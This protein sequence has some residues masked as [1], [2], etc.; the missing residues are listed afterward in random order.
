MGRTNLGKPRV[1]PEYFTGR[2]SLKELVGAKGAQ[3]TRVFDVRFYGGART[4][5]HS[6]TGAQILIVTKGRGSLVTYKRAGTSKH[7][8]ITRVSRT[9]LVPNKVV[10]IPVKTLHTHG[11]VSKS[12]IF[13]HIAVNLPSASSE[14]VTSW[15]DSDLATWLARIL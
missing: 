15:F 11:S 1:K 12:E 14:M 4:K 8:K 13:S 2:V 7:A 5:L 3:K 6:H 9:S 10:F